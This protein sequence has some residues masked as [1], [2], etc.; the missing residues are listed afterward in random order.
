MVKTVVRQERVLFG[1]LIG[2]GI[3]AIPF[4]FKSVRER[5]KQVHTL[6]EKSID[7]SD[8]HTK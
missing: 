3:A 2:L 8:T 6:R 1:V 4:L 5:E 7:S